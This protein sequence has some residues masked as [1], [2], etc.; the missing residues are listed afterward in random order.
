MKISKLLIPVVAVALIIIFVMPA[1]GEKTTKKKMKEEVLEA[2][3][4]IKK[5]SVEQRDEA[6][7]SMKST[8]NDMDN[9]IEEM[10]SDLNE[11][12]GRMSKSAR[13][14]KQKSIRALKKKRNEVAEWYGGLK[15]GSANAWNEIK[16]GFSNAY[17]ALGE[18]MN[19]A[20]SSLPKE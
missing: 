15:H 5:Y 16:S 3:E 10:E 12:W 19:K 17:K 4:M 14:Q 11:K 9:R 7:K 2:T 1:F 13:E 6:V 18:A 20:E 8:L